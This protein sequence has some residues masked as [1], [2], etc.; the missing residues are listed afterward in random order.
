MLTLLHIALVIASVWIS[1][2]EPGV[3]NTVKSSSFI[4]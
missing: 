3:K 1:M 2:L 4:S